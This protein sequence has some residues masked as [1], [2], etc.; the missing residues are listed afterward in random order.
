[1]LTDRYFLLGLAVMAGAL[2]FTALLCF[3]F[4]RLNEWLEQRESEPNQRFEHLC[5]QWRIF[6]LNVRIAAYR[7]KEKGEASEPHPSLCDVIPFPRL[8]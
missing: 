7:G 8:P 3:L 2:I 4:H 1:M 5:G 6:L